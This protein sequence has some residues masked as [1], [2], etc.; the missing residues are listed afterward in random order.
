[1]TAATTHKTNVNAKYNGKLRRSVIDAGQNPETGTKT[2][3]GEH[4]KL[5]C[6]AFLLYMF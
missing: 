2:Q 1:M 6:T 4:T 3:K 5:I